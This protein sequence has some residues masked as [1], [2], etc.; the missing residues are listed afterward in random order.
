VETIDAAG[1]S[2]TQ[3]LGPRDLALVP[4]GVRHR[5][6]NRDAATARFATIVGAIGAG[7]FGWE[8]LPAVSHA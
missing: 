1:A 3:R 5:L 7:P 6:V 4:A 8:C 2:T